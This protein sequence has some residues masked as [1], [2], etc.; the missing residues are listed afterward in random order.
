MIII[1]KK[2]VVFLEQNLKHDLPVNKCECNK[3]STVLHDFK[4][5]EENINVVCIHDSV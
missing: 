3:R 1:N 2:R 4:K 5:L